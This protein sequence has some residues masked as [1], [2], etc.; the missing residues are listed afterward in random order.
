MYYFVYKTHI[1]DITV[2]YDEAKL[3]NEQL[4]LVNSKIGTLDGQI[5]TSQARLDHLAEH[6]YDPECEFCIR[7]NL[8][9]VGQTEQHREEL[10]GVLKESAELTERAD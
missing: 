7:N 1:Q 4:R 10:A 3:S 2:K 9:L 8:S 5:T 6:D